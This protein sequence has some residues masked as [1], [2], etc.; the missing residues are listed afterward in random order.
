MDFMC[1]LFPCRFQESRCVGNRWGCRCGKKKKQETT[2]TVAPSPAATQAQ[3]ALSTAVAPTAEEQAYMNQMLAAS[4]A[5]LPGLQARA[6]ETGGQLFGAIS[7]QAQQ[8]TDVLT[9]RMAAPPQINYQDIFDPLFQRAQQQTAAFANQRGIVGSG[10]ELEKLGRA[11][12][13]LTLGQ[14]AARQQNALLNEQLRASTISDVANLVASQGGMS[15]QARNNLA[16]YLTQGLDQT[17]AIKNRQAQG[18]ATNVGATQ[19]YTTTTQTSPGVSPWGTIGKVAGSVA[20]IAAAPY[21]G[22]MSLAALPAINSI[23][24]GG[25]SQNNMGGVASLL[26]QQRAMNIPQFGSPGYAGAGYQ[27]YP[28][29]YQQLY[30][31]RY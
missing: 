19:G 10:L 7:P 1:K 16:S 12:V 29:L 8:L 28:Q 15:E 27:Q 13:D 17:N 23:P 4:Q 14:A 3:Q 30:G 9:Q 25:G 21:T 22:G 26:N 6:G 24:T 31:G 2:I 18:L 5:R 11:G 20:A